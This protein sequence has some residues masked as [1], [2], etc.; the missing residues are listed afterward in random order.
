MRI[1]LHQ[2]HD[3][4]AAWLVD[5]LRDRGC[6]LTS[7]RAS[8]LLRDARWEH[9]LGAAG[10]SAQVDPAGGPTLRSGELI[11]VVNRVPVVGV[12]GLPVAAGDREYADQ[13]LFALWLSWLAGLPCPVLNRPD[14]AGLCGVW[15]TQAQWTARAARAGLPT[16]PVVLHAASEPPGPGLRPDVTA[17]VA[18]G[19]A[20]GPPQARELAAPCGELAADVGADMLEVSFVRSARGLRFADASPMPDLRRG[21]E[22][23][24]DHLAKALP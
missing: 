18:C 13:E 16:E 15:L 3:P 7:V 11:A 10:P 23:L 8:S 2:D 17:V 1:L 5:G 6:E 4:S 12:D 19:A 20:F 21:G 14:P 9:R 24:L 22:P